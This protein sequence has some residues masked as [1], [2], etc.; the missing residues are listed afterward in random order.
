VPALDLSPHVGDA[1]RA[2]DKD[3][4]A[5]LG[6]TGKIEIPIRDKLAFMLF[7]S[8]GPDAIVCREWERCDIAVLDPAGRPD[9]IVEM[10]AAITADA[11]RGNLWWGSKMSEELENRSKRF[12]GIPIHQVLVTTHIRRLQ[13]QG[14]A[15]YALKYPDQV[16]GQLIAKRMND[17]PIIE[18]H[19]KAVAEHV[20]R[21]G[22]GLRLDETFDVGQAYDAPM[23]VH[24]AYWV[25]EPAA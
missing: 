25:V 14:K 21:L 11:D 9:H 13:A 24:A 6:L 22:G 8:L 2:F 15:L 5:Y 23:S 17:G 1:M 16:V 19:R 3:E 4:L 12:P 18:S 10:T 20:A 7:R